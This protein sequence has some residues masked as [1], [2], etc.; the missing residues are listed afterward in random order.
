[1]KTVRKKEREE[2]GSGA[3]GKE[4]GTSI[5]E[6]KQQRRGEKRWNR[7]TFA[8]SKRRQDRN[9][10]SSHDSK[11]KKASPGKGSWTET[12]KTL[13]TTV[14]SYGRKK[15]EKQIIEGQGRVG[16]HFRC[17]NVEKELRGRKGKEELRKKPPGPHGEVEKTVEQKK[18]RARRNKCF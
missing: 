15:N 5:K 14:A 3:G 17:N 16:S 13:D 6:K 12:A 4:G 1:L 8:G 7:C 11:K 10:N 18:W 2:T 9:R